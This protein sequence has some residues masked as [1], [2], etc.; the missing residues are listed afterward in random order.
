M[1]QHVT[2]GQ[3]VTAVRH[4]LVTASAGQ[5]SLILKDSRQDR[6]HAAT[7]ARAKAVMIAFASSFGLGGQFPRYSA[8]RNRP[9]MESAANKNAALQPFS[10][11]F[12]GPPIVVCG[13]TS[14]CRTTDRGKHVTAEIGT[15][16]TKKS[17][18]FPNTLL[19]VLVLDR[20]G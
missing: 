12:T 5:V 9:D 6:L 15:R 4:V 7:V 11:F 10:P 16:P 1:T 13:W 2:D 14:I 19:V 18:S 20:S 17:R 3:P 8:G